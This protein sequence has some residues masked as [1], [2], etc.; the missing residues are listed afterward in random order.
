VQGLENLKQDKLSLNLQ[1]QKN[2]NNCNQ[3]NS[4]DSQAREAFLPIANCV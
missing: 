3:S 4:T 1:K 2:E